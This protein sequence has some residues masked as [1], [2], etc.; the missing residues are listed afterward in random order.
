MGLPTSGGGRVPADGSEAFR[1]V[2]RKMAT[3]LR[4]PLAATSNYI[5]TARAILCSDAEQRIELA[6]AQLD[7]AADQIL[8]AGK[9]IREFENRLA[10]RSAD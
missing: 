1:R 2:G 6:I 3:D 5:G 10:K 4:Q 7:K 8:R 9:I